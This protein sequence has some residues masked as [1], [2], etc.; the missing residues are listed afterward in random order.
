MPK[1]W[2]IADEPTAEFYN[3]HPELPP[4]V[5][6]LLW[7][8]NLR[9]QTEIDE[10]LNPDYSSDLH[11]P[12]LFNDMDKACG[13]IFGAL[14]DQKKIMVHGDYDADG[15][16]A[17]TLIISCLRKFG[18]QNIEAFLPH[19]ETDGYGLN[20]NTVKSFAEQGVNLI[21]TCD[22]GISN[23]AEITLAKELGMEVIVTDHHSMPSVLP[24]ADAIIHPLVPGENYPDKKLAGGGVAFKLV[25]ALLKKH[26]EAGGVLMD[27]QTHESFEKWSIDL[28]AIATIGDMVPL[29]GESR[30]IT[31]YGLTV[32]NKTKN[33]GL[34]KL[35]QVAKIWDET[36]A[37]KHGEIDSETVAFKL[38]PRI[39]AAG[40]MAHAN[41]ALELLLAD[42]GFDAINLADRLNQNNLE[43]QKLTE[44]LLDEA[45]KQI[46][47]EKQEN[48]SIIFILGEGW[49]TGILG[50]IAGRL[51][52]EYARPVIVMGK[53]DDKIT[54]SGRSIPEYSIIGALQSIPQYFENFGGHPQACGFSLKS[55]AVLD[56]FK[57]ALLE[58]ATQKL[59][60]IDLTP[61]L[62][63]DSVINLEDITWELYDV[64]QNFA[65]F[66]QK[67]E[68]PL[69]VA[70]G[71]TIVSVDPVGQEGKHLRLLAKHNSHIVKKIIGFGLGD[72]NK[73]PENWRQELRPGV[74]IDLVFK[75]SLNEWN[76]NRELQLTVEDIKKSA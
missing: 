76:G 54:G 73:H 49:A 28:A 40:R 27:G 7:N 70:Y 26:K 72:T 39:N 38:V 46:K 9:T 36:N 29:T 41:V 65:P 13:I 23:T 68:A 14:S 60:D 47:N 32:L 18:G 74:K 69:Y 43:R 34:Q 12:F 59:K 62:K 31:K 1:H 24:P 50:L 48:N 15:V 10:F 71:L 51:K 17:A 57:N 5:V 53:K 66:G 19:R 64:L 67:N 22:C 42:N 3:E 2:I 8:R 52:D 56:V 20:M 45:H 21:I 63:I 75:I 33:I 58:D 25:Q 55:V 61:S 35:F 30:T 44:Q 4:L 6:R 16:C 11:D 37:P